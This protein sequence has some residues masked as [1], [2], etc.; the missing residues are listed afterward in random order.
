MTDH[1]L[2]VPPTRDVRQEESLG[3]YLKLVPSTSGRE[4]GWSLLEVRGDGSGFERN[5]FEVL[6]TPVGLG[7][8]VLETSEVYHSPFTLAHPF[9]KRD[10]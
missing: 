3:V 5:P 10:E 6:S 9:E 4:S 8:E 1:R 2:I 7:S